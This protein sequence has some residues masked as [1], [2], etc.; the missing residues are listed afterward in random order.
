DAITKVWTQKATFIGEARRSA[1]AF[2][3][4]SLAYV[5][6]GIANSG[7]K[8]DMFKYSAITNSWTQVADFGGTARKEAVAWGFGYQAFIATGDDGVYRDDFWMYT[9]ATDTWVQKA[10]F[11]GVPRKGA[12]AWG[13]FP[14]GFVTT[15]EDGNFNFLK[16]LWEYNF[17]SDTWTQRADFIGPARSNAIAFVLQ[18][19]AF[20][21]SGYDGVFYDDMYSY[22]RVLGVNSIDYSEVTVYPNPV[23]DKFKIQTE[24]LTDN[25]Q[26]FDNSGRNVTSEVQITSSYK[27]YE[28]QRENLPA[29][30]YSIVLS[31]KE[32]GINFTSKVIFL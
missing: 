12:V 22:T 32:T 20:V 28:V 7:L 18:G 6:T 16:D 1:V 17:Y 11:P 3:I 8:K 4:D 21:G 19:V 30:N 23:N 13:I 27:G 5:G 14:S 25:I 9:P 2:V 15:G 24:V 31:Q 10:N 29:G 26:L